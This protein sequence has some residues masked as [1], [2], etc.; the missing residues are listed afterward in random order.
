MGKRS[1]LYSPVS[2]LHLVFCP[3]HCRCTG[4]G[5]YSHTTETDRLTDRLV[6][7]LSHLLVLHLSCTSSTT[8]QH[9][10]HNHQKP[11]ICVV[12][13]EEQRV[14]DKESSPHHHPIEPA[15]P[16]PGARWIP[17]AASPVS[18]SMLGRAST[19]TREHYIDSLSVREYRV[20]SSLSH[21]E[22]AFRGSSSRRW[23]KSVHECLECESLARTLRTSG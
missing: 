1:A 22:T 18:L 16:E 6:T 8:N 2:R 20:P 5:N 13:Q 14:N 21:S 4:N 15:V 19:S 12:L 10:H 17:H 11:A 9:N 23:I 3:W 7:I